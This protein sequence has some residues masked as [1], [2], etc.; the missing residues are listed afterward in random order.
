MPAARMTLAPVLKSAKH[1][2][3]VQFYTSERNAAAL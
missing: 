3:P 1:Q 2:S